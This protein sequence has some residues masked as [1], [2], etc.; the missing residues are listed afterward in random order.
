MCSVTPIPDHTDRLSSIARL[1]VAPS[2]CL[3]RHVVGPATAFDHP[4]RP[5]G[6]RRFLFQRSNPNPKPVCLCLPRQATRMPSN[7]Y[8]RLPHASRA[9]HPSL[10]KILSHSRHLQ[11]HLSTTVV[12][13]L[14]IGSQPPPYLPAPPRRAYHTRTWRAYAMRTIPPI[15]DC[16]NHTSFSY[17]KCWRSTRAPSSANK[18]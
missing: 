4:S 12:A 1:T 3:N 10:A 5:E 16:G 18:A 7:Y 17:N 14:H 13:R 6:H 2:P 9:R 15:P 8:T 11:P